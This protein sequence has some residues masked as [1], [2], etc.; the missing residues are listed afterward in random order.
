MHKNF[1]LIPKKEIPTKFRLLLSR[2]KMAT[3]SFLAI[4]ERIPTYLTHTK[5][6]I[7]SGLARRP[8]THDEESLKTCMTRICRCIRVLHNFLQHFFHSF[9]NNS[10]CFVFLNSSSPTKTTS[11]RVERRK[12]K[13]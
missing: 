7:L 1:F 10:T 8:R 3:F 5:N 12:F 2:H 4:C 9:I 13:T 11:S 6:K